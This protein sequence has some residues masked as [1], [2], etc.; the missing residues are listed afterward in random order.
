MAMGRELC[1]TAIK[2]GVSSNIYDYIIVRSACKGFLRTY[3]I[4]HK[5]KLSV[6]NSLV[7]QSKII[8]N[9]FDYIIV[10]SACEGFLRTEINLFY[11]TQEQA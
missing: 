3:F 6:D 5:N 8:D 1:R 4:V 9:V 10:R 11:C 7:W 2:F